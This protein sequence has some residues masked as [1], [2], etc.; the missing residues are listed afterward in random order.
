[1]KCVSAR[2]IALAI[3]IALLP[4][5]RALSQDVPPPTSDAQ[6]TEAGKT[7]LPD[8]TGAGTPTRHHHRHAKHH[9]KTLGSHTP[10]SAS[11]ASTQ[12]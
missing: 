3:G 9:G 7:A 1:M 4:A 12:R 2:V 6:P 5:G 8:Q 10:A 11:G